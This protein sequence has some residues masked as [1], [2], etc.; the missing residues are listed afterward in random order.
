VIIFATSDKG[1]TGRS[2]TSAN[3]M[4]RRALENTDVAYLDFDFG[5]PTAGAIFSVA[6]APR[7]I[8]GRG[9]HS[10][11]QG[12]VTPPV[13]LDVWRESDLPGLRGRP[14]GA[15]QLVLLPGDIGG[16]EF[17]SNAD[18][19]QRCVELLLTVEAEFELSLVDLSAGRSFATEI[20][21][22][23]TA[24]P[25]M[26]DVQSRW[27]VYH[28]WTRQHIIAA[29]GLVH[30]DRG[31][32]E[33]GRAVGHDRDAL[34]SSVRFVHTAVVNPDDDDALAGLRAEQ[35]TWLHVC[36]RDLQDLTKQLRMGRSS[37]LGVVPLDPVLQWREQLITDDDT[38]TRQIANQS[39]VDAFKALA[40]QLTDVDA[41]AGL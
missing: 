25:A 21:L 28:R 3:V 26:R 23:A 1:G 34:A 9:L 32:L 12:R 33:T 6:R 19:V 4:Y 5:S 8:A 27:L 24:S 39:T 18:I 37:V 22:R 13:R 14:D 10:Y 7:G 11:L 35:I 16:G 15:G 38:I 20:V 36:N 40:K 30:G 2:V 31:L 41:W 29:N 17:A